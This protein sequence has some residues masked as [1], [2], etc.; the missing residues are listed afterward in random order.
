[1]EELGS[2]TVT[3]TVTVHSAHVLRSGVVW[4]PSGEATQEARTQLEGTEGNKIPTAR[5]NKEG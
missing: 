4:D 2:V 5:G 1:M 3:V